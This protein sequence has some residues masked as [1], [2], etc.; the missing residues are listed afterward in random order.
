MICLY[1]FKAEF[2]GKT[3]DIKMEAVESEKL[4]YLPLATKQAREGLEEKIKENH[5]FVNPQKIKYSDPVLI[6]TRD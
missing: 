6:S 5:W 4:H 2:R 3:Y 1:N